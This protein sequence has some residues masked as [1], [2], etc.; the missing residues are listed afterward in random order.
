MSNKVETRS[1]PVGLRLFPS[2]KSALEDAAR[3]D[4]RTT[5]SM[6]EKIITDWLREN[7][8]LA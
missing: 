6:A 8:H 4:S 7:G 2:T 1:A 5:A 3:K